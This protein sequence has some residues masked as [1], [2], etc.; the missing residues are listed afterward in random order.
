MYEK[1]HSFINTKTP[2]L[3]KLKASAGVSDIVYRPL[4]TRLVAQARLRGHKTVEG[5]GMLLHQARPGFAAWFGVD[6][7]VS[8]RLRQHLVSMLQG[9]A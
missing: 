2:D 9:K 8:P 4:E 1:K 7:V 5:L 3:S 6:P